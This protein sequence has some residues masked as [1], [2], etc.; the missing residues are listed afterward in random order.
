MRR[1]QYRRARDHEKRKFANLMLYEIKGVR[2]LNLEKNYN[3]SLKS[4]LC[5]EETAEHVTRE[6]NGANEV[7]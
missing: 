5:L 1:S 2:D 6:S 7:E 4:V 3:F